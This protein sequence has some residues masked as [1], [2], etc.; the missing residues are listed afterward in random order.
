MIRLLF[1]PEVNLLLSV[2][3]FLAGVFLTVG[4]MAGLIGQNEPALV[5]HM[6]AWALIVSGY[7][8]ILVSVVRQENANSQ[9][10]SPVDEAERLIVPG[11]EWVSSQ[12]DRVN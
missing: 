3:M 9:S 11:E 7:G 8:N 6:S 10:D 4:R 5:F 1:R 2:L 12:V